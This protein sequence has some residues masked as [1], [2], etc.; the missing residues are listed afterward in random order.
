MIGYS[1]AM[2]GA[3]AWKAKRGRIRRPWRGEPARKAGLTGAALDA[4]V[5]RLAHK[6]PG[7]VSA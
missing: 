4:W 1:E 7:H 2:V 5:S 6:Y 3:G